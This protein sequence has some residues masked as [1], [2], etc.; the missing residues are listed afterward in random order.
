MDAIRAAEA[1]LEQRKTEEARAALERAERM[2]P[3]YAGPSAPALTLAR[4]HEAAGDAR[5]AA[6][7]LARHTALD[8]S[9]LEANADEARL[10][11]GFGDLTGAAAALMR[12]VWIAPGDAA[13]HARLA[14][15]LDQTGDRAGALRERRAVLAAGAADPLEARYQLARAMARAGDVVGA[16]REILTVLE[17]APAFEKAQALLLE[18]RGRN[19]EERDR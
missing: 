14:D 3:E 6:A 18:L 4:L 5:A 15:L 12:S 19:P 2:F 8:E 17:S 16:R 11:Q 1:L 9:A 13:L 10:R 7:A